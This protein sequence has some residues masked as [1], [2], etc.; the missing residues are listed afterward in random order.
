[1]PRTADHRDF[2][3]VLGVRRNA[4]AGAIRRAFHDRARRAHPDVATDPEA[5]ERFRELG[6][7]YEVLSDPRARLLYD[8]LAYR[9]PGGGGFGPV[10]AGVGRPTKADEHISDYE[11]L[12]WI[13][14]DDAPAEPPLNTRDDPVVLGV[15]LVALLTALVVLAALLLT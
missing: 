7:A 5:E 12:R 6:H 10:H 1:M 15:A 3:D 4:D 8:R 11:L 2:Y 14:G 9:G 13:F